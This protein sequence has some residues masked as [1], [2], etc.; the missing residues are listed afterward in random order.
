MKVY[1]AADHGGFQMKEKIKEWLMQEG[2]EVEDCG[3]TVMD[4]SD[5][6][7]DFAFTAAEK[8]AHSTEEACGILFCRSGGG[9]VIAANKV[10]GIRAV[11]VFDLTSV[12][13]ARTHNNANIISL[14]GDWIDPREAQLIVKNFLETNF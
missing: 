2:Y 5:D 6:Y 13:H 14:G 4:E 1:L 8:V 3:N 12:I 11:D 9:M 10:K 7:T